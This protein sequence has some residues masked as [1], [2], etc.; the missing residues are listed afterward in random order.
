MQG[1]LDQPVFTLWI[2]ANDSQPITGELTFGTVKSKYHTGSLTKLPVNSL[3]SQSPLDSSM[4]KQAESL[5][6][7]IAA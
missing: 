1:L 6:Q 2:S 7:C 5:K 3:V 4:L